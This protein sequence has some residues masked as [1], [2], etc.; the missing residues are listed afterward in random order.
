MKVQNNNHQF[1]DAET[2]IDSI[3][4]IYG[5]ILESRGGKRGSSNSRNEDY[6]EALDL[7]LE[8]IKDNKI[9]KINIYLSSKPI[10][11]K[12][13]VNERQLIIDDKKTI[14]IKKIIV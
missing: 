7:I 14:E 1:L 2:K 12:Y 9:E 6:I 4:G 11:K 8:R 5:L 13:S 10:V 3:D